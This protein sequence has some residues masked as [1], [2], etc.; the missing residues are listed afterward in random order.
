MSL[1]VRL[2]D[3]LVLDARV[4]ADLTERSI[5]GQI[6]FWAGLGKAIE[7]LLRL[8]DVLTLKKRGATHSLSD[9]LQ[10]VDSGV[11]RRRLEET[12]SQKPFPHYE[13]TSDGNGLIRVEEDGT[14][15]AGRFVNRRFVAVA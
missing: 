2:S 10:L 1:P 4:W 3:A 13:P 6:E 8:D 12:L 14:R 9:C 5:A 15:T 7:S 11:S